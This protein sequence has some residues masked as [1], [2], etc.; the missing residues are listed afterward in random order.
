MAPRKAEQIQVNVTA[1]LGSPVHPLLRRI[2]A[3]RGGQQQAQAGDTA[4]S[5]RERDTGA[6]ASRAPRTPRRLRTL[7]VYIQSDFKKS[8]KTAEAQAGARCPSAAPAPSPR[9]LL[10][11][12]GHPLRQRPAPAATPVPAHGDACP[13]GLCSPAPT[14]RRRLGLGPTGPRAGA[15][16]R[17]AAPR[18]PSRKEGDGGLARVSLRGAVRACAAAPVEAREAAAGGGELLSGN[19]SAGQPPGVGEQAAARAR[20]AAGEG[21]RGSLLPSP[22][23]SLS[24]VA[25]LDQA[26]AAEGA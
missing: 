5:C 12:A 3:E 23:S 2:P 18:P 16:P 6:P 20:P 4:A 24:P 1:S 11:W 8:K 19:S 7:C 13:G 15:A 10:G 21:V 26:V 14:L 25:T 17:P 9:P 22:P